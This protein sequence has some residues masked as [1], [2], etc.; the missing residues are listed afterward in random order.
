MF[1]ATA[2]NG[3]PTST[4]DGSE[5]ICDWVITDAAGNGFG[6]ELD[7]YPSRSPADFVQQRQI[8]SGKTAKVSGLGDEAFSEHA[9]AGGQVFEDV[10]VRHGS[11]QF[12]LDA[13]KDLDPAPLEQLARTVLTRL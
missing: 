7:V 12:R 10:W 5:T 4:P 1:G 3:S 13:V 9:V 6:V 11:V 8:A 2:G